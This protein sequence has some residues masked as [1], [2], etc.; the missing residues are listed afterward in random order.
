MHCLATSLEHLPFKFGNYE[1]SY[2][3]TTSSIDVNTNIPTS[4]SALLFQK[5]VQSFD[6]F[7]VASVLSN[8][9]ISFQSLP[10]YAF[11]FLLS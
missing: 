8:Q 3:A 1:W 6:V 7:I 2:K 9:T 11:F 4:L 10:G 5:I